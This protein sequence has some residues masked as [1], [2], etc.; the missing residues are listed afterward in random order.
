MNVQL[1]TWLGSPDMVFSS[2]GSHSVNVPNF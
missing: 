2:T 1:Y